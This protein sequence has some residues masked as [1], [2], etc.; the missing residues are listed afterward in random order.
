MGL[1]SKAP[2]SNPKIIVEGIEIV[3]SRPTGLDIWE[4]TYRGTKFC[5]FRPVFAF[6]AKAELDGILDALDSLKPEMKSRLKKNLKLD[7]GESYMVNVQ[8]FA[9][10]RSFEVSWSDGASRGDMGVDFKIRG[11]AIINEQWGD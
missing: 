10:E 8:D 5:S 11:G 1:F 3:F 9:T 4:F 7:D 2:K 6:P